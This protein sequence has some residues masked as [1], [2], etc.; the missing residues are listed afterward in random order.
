MTLTKDENKTY[1]P[2]GRPKYT[3]GCTGADEDQVIVEL[4]ADG[5]LPEWFLRLDGASVLLCDDCGDKLAESPYE[6][7]AAIHL[8]E[9]VITLQVAQKAAKG[10]KPSQ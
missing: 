2:D 6:L 10:R 1:L 3:C 5:G 8:G 9:K 7:G 4:L